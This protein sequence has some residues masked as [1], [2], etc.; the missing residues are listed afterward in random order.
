MRGIGHVAEQRDQAEQ[1]RIGRQQDRVL[2]DG[3]GGFRGEHAGQRVRIHEGRQRRSERQRRV[4]K[5]LAVFQRQAGR[6][7][8]GCERVIGGRE[9]R[10]IAAE[11]HR[12]HH[13]RDQHH[14]VDHDVLDEGD[15]RR[16][17]QARA[18]GVERQ[19]DEGDDDR[20]FAGQS[21]R[22]DHH[23][24]ADQL[25]RDIGHGRD[26]PGQRH[27]ELERARAV[28]AVH[29]VGRG[30]V[31]VG[32]R[33]LPQ[34]RHDSEHEGIDDDGVGQ[35]EEAV[36]AD[37]VDQRRHRDHGVGGVE[38]AADQEPGDPGA[39]LAAAETPFIEM[40]LD[41]AGFPACREESHHGDEQEEENENRKRN[42]FDLIGHG[43][44]P[45][46]ASSCGWLR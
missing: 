41:L 27:R 23:A 18:V 20:R 11:L 26:Q 34:D 9:H 5:V 8:L 15:Q 37:R 33:D 13:D 38:I 3:V 21:H 46:S 16:R 39:E 31:A 36:G 14:D 17:T 40:L 12:H 43:E 32:M 28:Y 30:D 1:Q 2:A 4:S 22:L 35:R 25:Q 19:H 42:P 45:Y 7:A 10:A 29:D 24:H 44:V 6:A